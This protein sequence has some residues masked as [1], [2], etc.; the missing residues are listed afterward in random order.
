M[1]TENFALKPG[2]I[3]VGPKRSYKIIKTLGQGGFGIT[4]L[5]EGEIIDDNIRLTAKYALKEHFL[6]CLCSRD[7]NTQRIFYSQPVA[8]EVRNSLDSFVKEATRLQD[9]GLKH[10]NIVNINEVFEANNTAYYVME[11]LEGESLEDFVKNTEPLTEQQ[12]VYFM[13]P[14]AD[15][16][17]L[18]HRNNLT[19]YDIKPSNIIIH[20]GSDGVPRPVLID[21]GLSKHYDSEGHATSMMNNGG[22]S[23]GYSPIEQYS[24]LKSFTPQ[25]DVYAL[26]A[27]CYFCLTGHAPADAATGP[28][29]TLAEDLDGLA[30]PHTIEAL[31]HAM[32]SFATNRTS[33]ASRFIAE[34]FDGAEVEIVNT[35][36]TQ[37]R[38]SNPVVQSVV[39]S[40]DDIDS[41][42]T[43]RFPTGGGASEPPVVDSFDMPGSS[44]DGETVIVTDDYQDKKK[45]S[46]MLWLWILIAVVAFGIGAGLYFVIGDGNSKHEPISFDD[47]DA[48][49][50]LDEEEPVLVVDSAEVVVEAIDSTSVPVPEQQTQTQPQAPSSSTATQQTS[51]NNSTSSS[52]QKSKAT[53][54]TSYKKFDIATELH[55]KRL[56]FS[57]DEWNTLTGVDQNEYN[58]L[59]VVLQGNT[60]PFIVSFFERGTMTW[61]EAAEYGE[62]N[63]MLLGYRDVIYSN[64]SQLNSVLT[65]AGGDPISVGSTYWGCSHDMDNAWA[66][67]MG[68]AA[69]FS[70]DKSSMYRVRTVR[71]L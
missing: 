58:V 45:K 55:G 17:A 19:H 10:P 20:R 63:L 8:N 26:A 53:G 36:A 13:R 50:D 43:M 40:N 44:S 61:D 16:V 59:G 15:A 64:R 35:R 7:D 39:D 12:T 33:D 21:F 69:G 6:G 29:Q 5:V 41:R 3:V 38:V 25:A 54:R 71:K 57:V 22:F 67:P 24:G 47:E 56:Y 66:M 1:S 14:I 65:A 68:T 27:T 9:N 60:G 49:P 11:Y 51:N 70:V 52:T 4:Y 30:S 18:L 46:G 62:L 48:L 37:R 42:K 34:V 23:A 28:V 2:T 31:K 32:A